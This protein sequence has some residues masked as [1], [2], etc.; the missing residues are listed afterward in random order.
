MKYQ[1]F[2]V[3]LFLAVVSAIFLISASFSGAWI[4]A[5]WFGLSLAL[6]GRGAYS[7]IINN[8]K[9]DRQIELIVNDSQTQNLNQQNL[10]HMY[11]Q[12]NNAEIRKETR[13]GREHYVIPSYTLPDN[14]V[15]NGGL[16]TREE[17]DKHYL[18]LNNTFAPLGHPKIDDQYVSASLPM[19]IHT[20]HVGAWNEGVER[21]GNRIYMEKWV[22][23]DYAL[24]TNRGKELIDAI[25]KKEP[26]HTSVA[27][28]AE[29]QLT[30]N[31]AGYQWKAKIVAMDHDAILIGEPGAATP[32]QGVGLFVN[33]ADAKP[34]TV[35]SG[36]LSA[37]SY[38][39]RMKALSESARESLFGGEWAYVDD[40]DSLHA[41]VTTDNGSSMYSYAIVD[42]KVTWGSDAK[43]V[44]RKESWQEK[45]PIVNNLLQMFKLG[46]N[47]NG[48]VTKVQP[49]KPSET[50]EMT[51]EELQAAISGA[52]DKQAERLEANVAA[53]IN[54]L[55]E[56]I[57]TLE[58]NNKE[59]LEKAK[60]SDTKKEGDMREVVAKKIGTL[61]AN[62]LSG[63][64][65]VEAFKAAQPNGESVIAGVEIQ[66]NSQSGAPGADYFPSAQ[67]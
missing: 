45:F 11:I 62:C 2:Y 44:Q 1:F 19:A 56:K 61:A 67:K 14:V 15:M 29:R 39:A 46:V 35:N 21:K 64:A 57:A 32:E 59:L 34:L 16:Y 17:V 27:V 40:F 47:S 55:V 31:A 5:A 26:I 38:G 24:Q 28:Y 22:D 60:E 48:E 43:P 25:E 9:L 37:D 4:A 53:Q 54:P 36:I 63:E 18:Q 6:S 50:T 3:H 20:N 30:P 41:I 23:I 51:P 42:G 13:N 12:V 33:V 66:A 58:A 65:L 8:R 7:A 10:Q 49:K 52:L